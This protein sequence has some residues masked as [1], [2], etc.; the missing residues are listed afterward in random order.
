M[1]RR[2]DLSRYFPVSA[3]GAAACIIAAVA[4]GYLTKPIINAPRTARR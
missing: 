3:F 2:K 4:D 1:A